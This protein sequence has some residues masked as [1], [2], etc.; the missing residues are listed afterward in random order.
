M[1]TKCGA[2][3]GGKCEIPVGPQGPQGPQGEAG[4]IGPQG[5][6][7]PQ[8]PK[9][10]DGLDG[11]QIPLV[12]NDFVLENDWQEVSN[13]TPQYAI[14]N[15]LLY[16][17]GRLSVGPTTASGVFS[18]L[19]PPSGLASGVQSSIAS[20]DSPLTLSRLDWA[21]LTKEL[22]IVDWNSSGTDIWSLD[23]VPPLSIR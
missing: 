17:R 23:S 7:G 16:M 18:T 14:Q 20:T 11:D 1:C 9:G 6:T 13:Q 21:N 12:W 19:N 5:L 3:C 15:E 10:D 2:N 4:P 22:N 8:G